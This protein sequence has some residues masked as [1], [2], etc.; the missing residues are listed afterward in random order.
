[1]NYIG[2]IQWLGD[3]KGEIEVLKTEDGDLKI[4][5][6]PITFQCNVGINE[7]VLSTETEPDDSQVLTETEEEA[8]EDGTE[9]T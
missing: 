2:F 8:E 6:K 5:G 9:D 4:G 3:D 1:M 7:D